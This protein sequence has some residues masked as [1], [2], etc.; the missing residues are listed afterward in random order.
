MKRYL[1]IWS[2]LVL[3]LAMNACG[4]GKQLNNPTPPNGIY[5]YISATPITGA[6]ATPYPSGAPLPT[7]PAVSGGATASLVINGATYSDQIYVL[8]TYLGSALNT[9][10][11][12][13][14]NI[15]ARANSGVYYGTAKI[16]F[17][18]SV[19]NQLVLYTGSFENG[20]A[21]N[22]GNNV[23]VLTADTTT[24]EPA[25]RLMFEDRWGVIVVLLKYA[26]GSSDPSNMYGKVWY[27]NF[28][29][30]SAN[31]LYDGEYSGGYYF[32]ANPNAYCWSGVITAG[33]YDCRNLSTPPSES[34]S[35]AFTFLGTIPYIDGRQA[36]GL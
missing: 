29:S 26:S 17:Y 7:P 6:T 24:G 33:P 21:S 36:L 30:S 2:T 11:P 12:V 28:N 32:P 22:T 15:N 16:R 25:Y 20:A 10:G 35:K 8:K 23:H 4:S 18:D 13:Q 9:P 14:I 5:P 1:Y 27:R 31:P 3:A 19:N 34:G